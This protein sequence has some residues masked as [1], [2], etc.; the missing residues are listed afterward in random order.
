MSEFECSVSE[1]IEDK[2][3]EPEPVN[4]QEPNTKPPP[5]QNNDRKKD[6][7]ELT[8]QLNLVKVSFLDKMKEINTIKAILIIIIAYVLTTSKLFIEI[9]GIW[10]PSLVQEGELSFILKVLI[11][12]LLGVNTIWFTSSYQVH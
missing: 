5:P 7:V 3:V 9:V 11:A 2:N 8:N 1:F 6:N 4:N 10:L 12:I